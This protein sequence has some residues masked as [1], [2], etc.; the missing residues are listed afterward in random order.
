MAI[1]LDIILRAE[2]S[3]AL[4]ARL[5]NDDR[6]R[7]IPVLVASTIEDRN[8]GFHLGA[9][10]YILKPFEQADLLRELRTR[11]WADGHLAASVA[12]SSTIR[13]LDRYLSETTVAPFAYANYRGARR[14]VRGLRAGHRT[15]ARTGFF[16][17]SRCLICR[18]SRFSRKLEELARDSGHSCYNR[19]VSGAVR[20]GSAKASRAGRRD[21]GEGPP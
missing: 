4:L 16:L 9:D 13:N 17:I 5:K 18:V 14:G 19:H 1:V 21:C 20:R 12:S 7:D 10:N 11:R 2:D 15:G 3:W 8:K 6:T